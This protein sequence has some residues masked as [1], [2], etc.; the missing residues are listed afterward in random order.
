[1]FL[2]TKMFIV[3]HLGEM[4]E[5]N[6]SQMKMFIVFHLGKM[7]EGNVF[8]DEDVYCLPFGGNVRRKCSY[9][10]LF[11]DVYCVLLGEM[12]GSFYMGGNTVTQQFD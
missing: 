4:L 9:R 5:G 12:L 3:F 2:Q 10:L 1:M 8:T 6:V 7:L 11:T